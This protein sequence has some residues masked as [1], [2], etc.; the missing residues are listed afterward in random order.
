[1]NAKD[2]HE[3]PFVPETPKEG[4]NPHDQQNSLSRENLIIQKRNLLS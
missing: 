3:E 1:M 2:P 4:E